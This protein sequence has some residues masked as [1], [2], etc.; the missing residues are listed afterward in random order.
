VASRLHGTSPAR[1]ARPPAVARGRRGGRGGRRHSVGHGRAQHLQGHVA[2][3]TAGP[4]PLRH[5]RSPAV[6]RSARPETAGADHHAAGMDH[7]LGVRV[8][9]ALAGGDVPRGPGSGP[10]RRARLAL[11]PGF[12]AGRARRA[13]GHRRGGGSGPARR[14]SCSKR[15]RR[16]GR[17]AWCRRPSRAST[18]RS[19]TGSIPGHPTAWRPKRG[20]RA[21]RRCERRR[22]TQSTPFTS[23]GHRSLCR[24]GVGPD[25]PR[26]CGASSV[27]CRSIPTRRPR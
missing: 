24:D 26:L 23:P 10:R 22:S 21:R 14:A 1:P 15:S 27:H 6:R 9:A 12:R 18:F 17:G 5:A 16:S 3:S 8:D 2:T 19:K 13:R 4:G 20:R 11:A 25:H 7:G